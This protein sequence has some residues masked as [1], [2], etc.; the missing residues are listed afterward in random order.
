MSTLQDLL[1]RKAALEQEIESTQKRERSDAIAKVRALMTEYGLNASDLTAKSAT[2]SGAPK[3][4]KV[5]AKYRNAAT[6]DS[7]SGR[8]LQ[9]KWLKA[10]LAS[11]KKLSDFAV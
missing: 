2:R 4:A 9:P 8:G 1:A 7:W 5:A 6:G 11:G 3:G 10:A